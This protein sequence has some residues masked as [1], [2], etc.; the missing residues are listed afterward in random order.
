MG[1]GF[2]GGLGVSGPFLFEAY[3]RMRLAILALCLTSCVTWTGA[4]NP[5]DTSELVCVDLA[6]DSDALD[7]MRAVNSWDR[8]IGTWH[9]MNPVRGKGCH[10]TIREAAEPPGDHPDALAFVVRGSNVIHLV[11]GR[12]H[13]IAEP[14]VVHE[15][16]HWLGAIHQEGT[17]MT[18]TFDRHLA[19]CPDRKTVEQVAKANGWPMHSVSWCH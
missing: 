15:M 16:G 3:Y 14:L 1:F 11:R 4:Y 8:A 5:S 12:Y 19:A 18:P 2:S 13:G 7:A 9:H 10:L 17:A 6:R